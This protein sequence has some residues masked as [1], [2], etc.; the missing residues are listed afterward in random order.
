MCREESIVTN[1]ATGSWEAFRLDGLT[2][3]VTGA[4]RGIG[5]ACAM[6]LVRSG[7][8]VFAVARTAD[9]IESLA[10]EAGP[11]LRGWCAD[12]TSEQFLL[13][14]EQLDRLDVLVNNV[15]TN[16]PA[17]FVDVGTADLD[18]VVS[19]NIRTSFRVAQSG[20]RAMLR[21]GHGGSVIHMSS[22]MGHVGA[23]LRSV[24][25][26]TKH[27]VEGLSKAMAVE[28]AP[29]GIR[30]NTVAPTFIETPMTRPMLDDDNFRADVLARIPLGRL[31]QP[32]DVAAAVVFL[33]SPAAALITG[34]SLKV[35]GGWTAR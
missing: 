32:E 13:Q 27:A 8:S 21:A 12:V 7:A 29:A 25:C 28:L 17:P 6:A 3:V 19:L 22:Q 16:R 9:D 35:D 20:V 14:L 10:Q 23:P 30:V 5:R 34:D 18:A 11:Q 15:G 31:G 24:Y 2:A 1:P 33:A 26:M 4:G